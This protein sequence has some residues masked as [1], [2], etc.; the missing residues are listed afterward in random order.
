VTRNLWAGV[1]LLVGAI[2]GAGASTALANATAT[3]GAQPPLPASDYSVR[4]VCAAPVLPGAASCLALQLVPVAAAARAHTHLLGAPPTRPTGSAQPLGPP[5]QAGAAASG[6]YGIRPQDLHSAYDLPTS[7]PIART[8]AIAIVDAYDD[9]GAEADLAIYD[10]EFGLPPCTFANGCFSK[11][12]QEGAR[13]PLPSTGGEWAME[14]AL[15][16]ETAHA[17]CETCRIILIEARSPAYS[18]LEAAEQR[19]V[20]LGA[21]EISDSWGGEEPAA[22][23]GA[24]DH[25]GIAITASSGDF[26]YRNWDAP[27]GGRGFTDYPASSPHVVAVGGTR[28]RM[29]SNGSWASERVWNGQGASGGGCSDR[30]QAPPWQLA[31]ADW[32]S[33]GCGSMRAVADVAADAD[34]YTGVAVYDSTPP[35]RGDPAPAWLTLGGTSLA[36]P[37]VAATFALAGGIASGSSGAQALYESALSTPGSIHTITAGSNGE[38]TKPFTLEGLSGCT[39]LEEAASCAGRAICLARPGYNGPAGVGTPDG[40]CAFEPVGACAQA[41]TEGIENAGAGNG[42][43]ANPGPTTPGSPGGET[44][45]PA[46]GGSGVNGGAP[47]DSS[48]ATATPAHHRARAV[49]VS[50]LTL[51][52]GTLAAL[53]RAIDAHGARPTPLSQI[54]FTYVLSRADRVRVTL[55]RLVRREGKSSWLDVSPGTMLSARAGSNRGRLAGAAALTSGAYLLTLRPAGGHARSLPF[56]VR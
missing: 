44:P 22:D 37:I 25:P 6:R 5:R 30:F 49:T 32:S 34:P 7:T 13:A 46:G 28:L 55:A 14:I 12:N 1:A 31:L 20:A 2:L 10:Q 17:V 29:G 41:R 54:A 16:V 24:F 26:G 15:D 33:V 21:T 9:P 50:R 18:D 48:R 45:P 39:A 3:P 8:Q 23:S 36:S 27:A 4:P 35:D 52:V 43:G 56:A 51:T 47:S 40:T 42:P 53:R 19:A 11:L 38:C